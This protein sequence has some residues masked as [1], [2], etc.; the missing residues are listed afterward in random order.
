MSTALGIM[1]STLWG[2]LAW[3]CDQF[4]LKKVQLLCSNETCDVVTDTKISWHQDN[5]YP[6]ILTPNANPKAEPSR[7]WNIYWQSSQILT[8]ETRFFF[9]GQDGSTQKIQCMCNHLMLYMIDTLHWMSDCVWQ[10]IS[11]QKLGTTRF[12]LIQY[13]RNHLNVMPLP[14]IWVLETRESIII[15]AVRCILG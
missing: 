2:F 3:N 15:R 9:L 6:Q 8:Q 4:T 7:A 14:G 12:G 11:P 10:K 13:S 1:A 5:L